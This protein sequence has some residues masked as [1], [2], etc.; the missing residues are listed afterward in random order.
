MKR[1]ILWALLSTALAFS[2]TDL[3]A[4]SRLRWLVTTLEP[5]HEVPSVASPGSGVFMASVDDDAREIEFSM[6]FK[7]LQAP[8]TQSHI[9][10]AQP[11]VNG[12]IVI[13]L[14]GTATNPGPAGTQT[15]PQDGTI[16]GTIRPE[17]V[18]GIAAQGINAGDFDKIVDNLRAGLGYANIHTV[19]SPGGEIRGQLIAQRTS[20]R[21]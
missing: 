20:R 1:P 13:W 18:L 7:N 16:T 2:A 3:G 19:A 17:N 10:F 21:R 9:H 15:C 4:A 5:R 8:V 11:S 6:S 14:C 12:G